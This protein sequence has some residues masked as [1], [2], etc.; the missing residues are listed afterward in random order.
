MSY[1]RPDTPP[2]E[3]QD[4]PASKQRRNSKGLWLA[5]GIALGA[6]MFSVTSNPV[7]IGVGLALG[8]AVGA[9][10]SRR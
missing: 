5:I 9:V 4:Q 10:F 1:N 8:L 7:Y 2:N 6:T 3:Q